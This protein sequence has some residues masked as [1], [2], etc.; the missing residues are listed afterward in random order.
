MDS[1]KKLLLLLI[2][3]VIVLG[4][5]FI[6]YSQL[7]SMAA[8]E[9]LL[10]QETTDPT[11]TRPP[12]AKAPDFTVY[13]AEGNPVKLSDF[14]GKPVV[15]NFWASWCG[16][17]QSEMPDFQEKY[18]EYG[19]EVQFLMVNMTDGSR[20]TVKSASE[21]IAGKGYT[22]PVY[23]DTASSAAI[24]YAVTSIPATYL[25]DAQGGAVAW[26]PGAISADVLQAGIDMIR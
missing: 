20:E 19:D 12:R 15:V 16:P 4:G 10:Q 24:T 6:L 8:P 26:I 5:A 21:F 22:F 3:F 13:D 9:Q 25:I 2:V 1:K 23:Y 17:C 18:L 11:Q 14:V 7:G